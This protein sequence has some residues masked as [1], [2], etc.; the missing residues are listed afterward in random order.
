MFE[1]ILKMSLVTI[2]YVV[3]TALVEIWVDGRALSRKAKIN[4]GMI[5]GVL[6]II[7]THF[8]IDYQK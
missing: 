4:I 3:L 1:M 8:G 2:L 5:Y 7:S 6:C